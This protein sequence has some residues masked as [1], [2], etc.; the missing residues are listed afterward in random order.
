MP[1]ALLMYMV[2]LPLTVHLAFSE[3]P[4][5]LMLSFIAVHNEEARVTYTSNELGECDDYHRTEAL[6]CVF[7][8]QYLTK[9]FRIVINNLL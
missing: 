1:F 7:T 9:S 2:V 6:S 4:L 8:E 5:H 3:Y